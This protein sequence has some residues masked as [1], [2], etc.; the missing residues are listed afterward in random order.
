MGGPYFQMSLQ[1]G[2]NASIGVNMVPM[3]V[4]VTIQNA[5][6]YYFGGSIQKISSSQT[7]FCLLFYT[8]YFCNTY[9]QLFT[10]TGQSGLTYIGGGFIGIIRKVKFFEYPKVQIE[11][12]HNQRL[13]CKNLQSFSL[14]RRRRHLYRRLFRL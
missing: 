11:I 14:L 10:D 7:E 13:A 8:T 9:N 3:F 1:Q 5:T 2:P 12:S 4:P 6:W